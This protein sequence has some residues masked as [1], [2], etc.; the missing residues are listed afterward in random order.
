MVVINVLGSTDTFDPFSTNSN[1]FPKLNSFLSNLSAENI[2][3]HLDEE[4]SE[5]SSHTTALSRER[6]W[7]RP[8]VFICYS[9][10]DCPKHLAV[11]QSFAFFLQDFCGCAVSFSL[12]FVR[13]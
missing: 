1:S 4:S 13:Y 7:P 11:I 2:Y 3:S 6:P 8:K 9:T 10:K 12:L 5:S